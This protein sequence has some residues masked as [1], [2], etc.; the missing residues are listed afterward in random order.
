MLD[1]LLP[2]CCKKYLYIF[3]EN[4]NE[5]KPFVSEKG[6]NEQISDLF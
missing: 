4:L 5:I 6:T 3:E 1:G 2:I